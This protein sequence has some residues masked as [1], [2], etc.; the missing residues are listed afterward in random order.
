MRPH[1]SWLLT[2]WLPVVGC[3]GFDWQEPSR[4]EREQARQREAQA[5]AADL[6]P[7]KREADRAWQERVNSRYSR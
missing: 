3:R 4:V 5:R 7:Q 6:D 2:L 1:P